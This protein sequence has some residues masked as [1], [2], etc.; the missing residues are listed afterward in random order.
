M[1]KVIKTIPAVLVM[2]LLF[3]MAFTACEEP[4]CDNCGE[5]TCVCITVWTGIVTAEVFESASKYYAPDTNNFTRSVDDELFSDT[6]KGYLTAALDETKMTRDQ[7]YD[8]IRTTMLFS[9]S[10]ATELTT[11]LVESDKN[12]YLVANNG[13]VLDTIVK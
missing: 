6:R 3:A 12:V 13:G 7:I 4:A 5:V 11:W 1:K 8:Y 10:Q 2:A 9:V